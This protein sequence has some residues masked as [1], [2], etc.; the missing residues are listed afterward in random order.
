M[1]NGLNLV[2]STVTIYMQKIL[3]VYSHSQ[4]IDIYQKSHQTFTPFEHQSHPGYISEYTELICVLDKA[5]RGI[6]T[7]AVLL[8]TRHWGLG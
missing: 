1:E 7:G 3:I 6:P 4:C 5:G 8:S 2:C